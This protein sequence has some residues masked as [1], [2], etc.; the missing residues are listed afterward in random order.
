MCGFGRLDAVS[1]TVWK[2]GRQLQ[3]FH[4]DAPG[5]SA[6]DK[7]VDGSGATWRF[8]T[9]VEVT[10]RRTCGDIQAGL[11]SARCCSNG[12]GLVCQKVGGLQDQRG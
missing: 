2:P 5:N 6:N 8:S 12:A 10:L 7:V 11:S 1:V 3:I 4:Q 9:K